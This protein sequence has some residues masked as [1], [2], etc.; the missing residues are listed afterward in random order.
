MLVNTRL[1]GRLENH[2][3][4][5]YG[6]NVFICINSYQL[7][8]GWEE[9]YATNLWV[10]LTSLNLATIFLGWSEY[11]INKWNNVIEDLRKLVE[12]PNEF[13]KSTLFKEQIHDIDYT[14]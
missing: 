9:T 12:Q 6:T 7:V 14:Q 1:C 13:L 4:T 2:K 5:K 10:K 3:I 8:Q 11:F